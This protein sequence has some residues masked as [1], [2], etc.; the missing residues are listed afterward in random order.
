MRACSSRRRLELVGGGGRGFG[1]LCGVAHRPAGVVGD[2]RPGDARMDGGDGHL[3]AHRIGLQDAEIGDEPGRALGAQAEP[4]PML[5]AL[6]M[7]QRGDEV[8]PLDE[9]SFRLAHDDENLAAAGADLGR[10]AAARQPGARLVIGADHGGVDIGEAVDLGAAEET[11]R[12]AAALQPVAE[13]LHHRDGGE[14][15]LAQLPVADRERQHRRLGAERTGLVDQRE[16]GRVRQARQV[17][18]GRR[19]PD[20]DEANIGIA[21]RA[22][23]RD[24]H[25]LACPVVVRHRCFLRG[26]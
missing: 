25:H 24:G 12:H 2:L 1:D 7:P 20:A 8:E 11:D 26:F 5:A 15:G 6:A 19:Q 10:P 9:V 17:G 14:R 21:Q 16:I 18:G 22:R 4:R 23:R 3:A 13:H